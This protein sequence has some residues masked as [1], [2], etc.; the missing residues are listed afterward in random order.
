MR[1]TEA[2]GK[3]AKPRKDG[4]KWKLTSEKLK[5]SASSGSMEDEGGLEIAMVVN[6]EE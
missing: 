5:E 1:S 2:V 6:D 4:S 3:E